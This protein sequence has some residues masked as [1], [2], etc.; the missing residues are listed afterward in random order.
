[1]PD[2][3]AVS[4]E[5]GDIKAFVA[6]VLSTTPD[7]VV[8]EAS[9]G[10]ER[11]AWTALAAAG[12]SVAIVN[13]KR[14]RDFARAMGFIA[15]TDKL[16]ARVLA[17]F[18]G[19]VTPAPTTLPSSEQRELEAVLLRYRQV[20]EMIT[21]EKNRLGTTASPRVRREINGLLRVLGA[22]RD[23]LGKALRNQLESVSE[24][25][26]R[27]A[28]LQSVP[29]VGP[30]TAASLLIDLPELGRLERGQVAALAGVAPMAHDSG[31]HRGTRRIQGG[32]ASVRAALYMAA[33][34]GTRFN[35]VLRDFYK[36]LLGQG[37]PKKVALT[38][39][40][41]KLLLRLNAMLRDQT[42]W[43]P[44]QERLAG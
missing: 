12:I 1:M 10:Y 14:V 36:R 42:A 32:R 17:E 16:D 4:F 21:A 19:R 38:A 5:S 3:R 43:N 15:K 29:G 7:L 37:K 24:L 35:P 26:E 25:Q 44:L 30:I 23:R 9:G 18:G 40:M 13:P 39:C 22:Q 8:M 28:R 27:A 6:W 41:R 2:G 11:A 20:T 31:K 34:V 33:L